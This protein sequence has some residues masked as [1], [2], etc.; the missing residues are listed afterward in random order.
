[1]PGDLAVMRN[2]N[3]TA[4]R[5]A[6]IGFENVPLGYADRIYATDTGGTVWRFD[7]SDA[8]GASGVAPNFVITQLASIAVPPQGGS[9]AAKDYR[10]F[11]FSPDVVYGKDANGTAFDAVLVGS[12]DREHPFDMVVHNRFYMFKDPNIGSLTELE[13]PLGN[14]PT[15]PAGVIRDTA[16][17][18]DLFDVTNN[19]LQDAANCASGQTQATAQ[20][21]LLAGRGWKLQ[22][23]FAGEKTVAMATTAAGTVIF[24]THEPKD[25][26]IT[27]TEG[28]CTSALGTARQYGISYLDATATNLF[29]GMPNQYLSGDGR[30]AKFAGGG[31][32]PAPVPVVVQIDGRYFQTVCS[33]IQCTNPGGLKLQSRVRTY[34]YRKAD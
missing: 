33:G 32:L 21:D 9:H 19:C 20:A 17:S 28:V 27:G 26:G 13:V 16:A 25:D 22:F 11:L 14:Q 3:N 6:D 5:A 4:S 8:S 1:M 12:G 24:N 18:T 23:A 29:E 15:P 30:S 2:R 10:K 31:F 34:W 7:V